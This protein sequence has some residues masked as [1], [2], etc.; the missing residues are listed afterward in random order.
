VVLAVA[1]TAGL[2]PVQPLRDLIA[3]PSP[4]GIQVVPTSAPATPGPAAVSTLVVAATAVPTAV[5]P[6]FAATVTQVPPTLARPSQTEWNDLQAR[7]DSGLWTSDLAASAD[8]L[9]G[10]LTKYQSENP[11][12]GALAREKLY[13]ANI[14]LGQRAVAASNF[15]GARDRFER[16]GQVKPNDLLAAGELKKVALWLAGDEAYRVGNWEAAIDNFGGLVQIDGNFGNAEQKLEASRVEL[17]KTWTPTPVPV[18]P[19]APAQP[20]S[21]QPGPSAPAPQ[22]AYAPAPQPVY[23]PTKSPLAPR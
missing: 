17:A 8:L 13:A 21:T 20:S 1:L 5:A 22:P 16:A 3:G 4:T 15:G 11:P 2:L 10:Y 19:Q 6:T 14:E 7:L 23:A 12:E 18:V 9:E